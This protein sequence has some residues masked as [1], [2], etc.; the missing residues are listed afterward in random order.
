[1]MKLNFNEIVFGLR[2]MKYNVLYVVLKNDKK[3]CC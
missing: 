2:I 1:M 3:V